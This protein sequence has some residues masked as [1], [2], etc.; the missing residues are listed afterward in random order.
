MFFSTVRKSD[1]KRVETKVPIG[2]VTNFSRA[3]VERPPVL[4][5]RVR[6]GKFLLPP[7]RTQKG[8]ES[9]IK[10]DLLP[11]HVGNP[12][13][14]LQISCDKSGTAPI[15]TVLL[16]SSAARTWTLPQGVHAYLCT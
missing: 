16:P 7:N 13:L 8:H 2:L 10:E 6:L 11:D 1:G 4:P 15:S 9:H 3:E 12:Y 14:W 5:I